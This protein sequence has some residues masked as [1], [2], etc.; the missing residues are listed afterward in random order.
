M[1]T[2]LLPTTTDAPPNVAE[3]SKTQSRP[4]SNLCTI[5]H[6]SI[7]GLD[8]YDVVLN[9][10]T[11][12]FA[13]E[14]GASRYK[15]AVEKGWE[16]KFGRDDPES[17]DIGAVNET[18]QRIALGVDPFDVPDIEGTDKIDIEP[19]ISCRGTT[20]DA[21]G[22]AWV[23]GDQDWKIIVGSRWWKKSRPAAPDVTVWGW[24][25][26]GEAK[27]RFEEAKGGGWPV[28]WSELY[29]LTDLIEARIPLV[30]R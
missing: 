18:G 6:Q 13:H 21:R 4:F 11:M 28:P 10:A 1:Q 17:H 25:E 3:I 27:A 14:L 30:S 15:R 19:N 20:D 16:D 5:R 7:F 12:E 29:C 24:I 8:F 26:A 23:R 9:D 2:S 22:N